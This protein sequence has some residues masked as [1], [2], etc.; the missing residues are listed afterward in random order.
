M[1]YGLEAFAEPAVEL[2][3]ATGASQRLHSFA[4]V[5]PISSLL[6]AGDWPALERLWV[7]YH[8]P[9]EEPLALLAARERLPRLAA[10]SLGCRVDLARVAPQ[11]PTSIIEL[12]LEE[13]SDIE[14]AA[15]AMSPA[16]RTLERLSVS[17]LR[18]LGGDVLAFP[19][20]RSLE[21]GYVTDLGHPSWG[22]GLM[23][24][25]CRACLPSLRELVWPRHYDDT[26][27]DLAQ[28][29]RNQLEL[30]DTF[31][32]AEG[33]QLGGFFEFAD[34]FEGCRLVAH[35]SPWRLLQVGIPL[36]SGSWCD[37]SS[38]ARI[39]HSPM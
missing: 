36:A 19:R 21:L 30:F 12:E 9:V 20:L 37:A 2:L 23:G 6:D 31:N 22:A 14:L 1:G 33:Q 16:G 35:N 10:L 5:F 11:F 8:D 24:S 18:L 38:R 4:S 3:V 32:F 28:D 13:S 39:T 29:L 17:S 7:H 25:L 27:R 26:P 34:G 15:L